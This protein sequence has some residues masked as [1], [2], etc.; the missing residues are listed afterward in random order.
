VDSPNKDYLADAVAAAKK[1]DVVIAV[2]GITPDLEGEE[3]RVSVEGFLGGDR[4]RID[5]PQPEEDLLKAL[6]QTGKR[7]VVVLTNGSALAVNRANSN[8]AAILE[9][10]YPGEEGGTAVAETLAGI[11]N[12]S[13]RLPVTFYKSVDQLPPVEDYSMKGRTYRYFEGEPL[14][15]FGYGLSY[16]KFRYSGLKIDPPAADGSVQLHATV[17][18]ASGREGDE[19]VQLYLS[20][21]SSHFTVPRRSLVGFDRVHLRPNE[22]R[23]IAFTLN[24]EQLMVL[25]NDGNPTL[26]RGKFLLGVGGQQPEASAVK[27]RAAVTGTF[28]LK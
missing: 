23:Q 11:N 9:A 7:M 17:K 26:E 8:A 6:K 28:E 20:K 25:D 2:V 15:P 12:P 24:R 19:V 27:T 18:N 13:G 14:Y 4:T 10:W 1:A 21:Q 5:L 22:L 3:M 16:S